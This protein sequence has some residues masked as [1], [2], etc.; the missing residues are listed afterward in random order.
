MG[1]YDIGPISSVIDDVTS[2][3]GVVV[4]GLRRILP[5]QILDKGG[6]P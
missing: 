4:S 2:G 3:N 5:I 6:C 1:G